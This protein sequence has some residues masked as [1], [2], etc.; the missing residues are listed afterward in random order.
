MSRC[1][2]PNLS[3]NVNECSVIRH[4][5]ATANAIKRL[6]AVNGSSTNVSNSAKRA[7]L[8][9]AVKEVVSAN[10][11][12]FAPALIGSLQ[13]LCKS[14]Y[15]GRKSYLNSYSWVNDFCQSRDA[16]WKPS[17][18]FDDTQGATDDPDEKVRL[19]GAVESSL[20]SRKSRA[21]NLVAADIR[22]ALA[23]Y[24]DILVTLDDIDW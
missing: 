1:A 21:A 17:S 3:E 14:R 15:S 12:S 22:Q 19:L 4:S 5:L 18:W 11:S 20:A 16:D 9:K 10:G 23:N 2:Q 7:A 6:D 13:D 8:E 24:S